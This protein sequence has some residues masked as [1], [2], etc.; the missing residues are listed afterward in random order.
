MVLTT[1]PFL[2]RA[3]AYGKFGECLYFNLGNITDALF[4]YLGG[5]PEKESISVLEEQFMN[6]PLVCL[7]KSW[8]DYI[9][10]FHP[11]AQV[12]QR[13]MM[14][15]RKTFCFPKLP[16]LPEG[17]ML[18]MMDDAV[19]EMHPF[20]HGINYP[21]FSAFQAEGSGSV[22]YHENEIVAS[23]SAFISLNGEIELDV[24]T[25][26][27]YRGNGLAQACISRM[28]KDCMER[29]ILVHWDAQNDISR[30]LAEKYGF[31]LDTEYSVYWL[32]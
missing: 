11:A 10:Q 25:K 24:F 17:Y 21:S 12:Y 20:S 15:P 29:G 6:R 22:V 28:L 4:V 8:E 26:N 16:I 30:H 2:C 23:A 5:E 14:K 19:F 1:H 13:F 32:P 18:M 7:T 9:R 27:E 31:E 3:A